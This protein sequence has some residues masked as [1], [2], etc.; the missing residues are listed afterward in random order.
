MNTTQECMVKVRSFEPIP[1]GKQDGW[2]TYRP[3]PRGVEVVELIDETGIRTF[4]QVNGRW[5]EAS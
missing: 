1:T 3:D 2:P 4:R 5:V